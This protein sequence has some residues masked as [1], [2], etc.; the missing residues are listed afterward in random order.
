[1]FS[2]VSRRATALTFSLIASLV[3]QIIPVARRGVVFAGTSKSVKTAKQ[4]VST[5]VEVMPPAPF[6]PNITA[7]KVDA[8]PDPNSDGKAEPGETITYTVTITNSGTDATGVQ[9]N[10]TIDPNTTLVNG[11]TATQPIAVPDS[12]NV[13]GNVRIQPNAAAGFLANDCDPDPAGGP[14][15]NS[16]LTVTTLAGDNSAPFA[17]TSTQSGQVTS[18]T[19]D[20]SFAYNPPPGFAGTDTFTYTVT[21]GTGKTDTATVTLQVGN[22][23][24]SPGANVI[25]FINPAAAAGGDGRLTAPFNCFRGTSVPVTGPTCFSDTAA[26]DPGDT[27]FLFSGAHTSGYT[28]LNNQKLVGAGALATLASIAGVTVQTYS[29]ALPATSQPSPTL[30]S[31][32]ITDSIALG[33]GNTIRGVTFGD[34]GTA[35]GN[36]SDINGN[37]FGTLTILDVTL[38]GSGRALNL[39][40]GTLAA[41]STIDA[42]TVTASTG[43]GVNLDTVAGSLTIAGTTSI[44]NQTAGQTSIRIN[45]SSGNFTFGTT[46]LDRRGSAG[47]NIIAASGTIQFGAVT[48]NNQNSSGTSAVAIDNTTGTGSITLASATVDNNN[49]ASANGIALSGNS[50]TININGGA[51]TNIAATG[52]GIQVSSAGNATVTVAASVTNSAGRSVQVLNRNGG[53]TTLSGNINDTGTGI[54]VA[55]NTAGTITFSGAT[56]TVN[57]GTNQAVTLN[58]NAGATIN[59]SNGGL[60]ITTTSGTGFNASGGG[61]ISVT[62]GANNNTISSGSGGAIIANGVAL[63]A[64]FSSVNSTGGT[65]DVSL[66]TVTGTSNFGSGALSGATGAAFFV[67]G[68]SATVTYSGTIT[69]NTASQKAVDISG[70]TGGT[71]TLSGAIGSNGGSGVSIAGT[72]GT[73]TISGDMTLNNSASVFSA[74]GSGLTVNATGTNNTIGATNAATTTAGYDYQLHHRLLGS[75]VQ[76]H[77]ADRRSKAIAI[78]NAGTLGAFTVTGTGTTAG[79]GGTIQNTTG[80]S[81]EVITFNKASGN[82]VVLNNMTFNNNVTTNTSPTGSGGTC[83]THAGGGDASACGAVLFFSS[84]TGISLTNTTIDGTT[85]SSLANGIVGNNVINMTLTQVTVKKAGNELGEDGLKL[86]GIAGTVNLDRVTITNNISNGVYAEP[87]TSTMNM[88]VSGGTF[89]NNTAPNGQQGILVVYRGTG[90]T[91]TVQK[92]GS[93]VGTAFQNIANHAISV[94][95]VASAT[96]ATVNFNIDSA[97]FTSCNAAID[98]PNGSSAPYNFNVTN[99][100]PH[101]HLRPGLYDECL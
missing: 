36:A 49:A 61:T 29:D 10:D 39:V 8:F 25:W 24:A 32:S 30:T 70:I 20:G 74:S 50:G 100:N 31:G 60:G 72:G 57:T 55:N 52:T 27:I 9:F 51:V 56:K 47:I 65:H 62:T 4:A 99:N 35:T 40:N 92:D 79:S 42:L 84:V 58:T 2:P 13:I 34:S 81:V 28:L 6:A 53:T 90:G 93:N 14:C 41:G 33:T 85:N 37:G 101:E 76:E 22:G 69:Q 21:D 82:S 91:V 46:N 19:T 38:N 15:T 86:V 54:N 75:Y 59:F 16:G 23:T 83:G 66:T 80:R 96:P 98:M 48:I 5:N 78:N 26:D 11:S 45:A 3:F 7:T 44:D 68:G 94:Q 88:T 67:S 89:G 18:S 77:L 73:V 12:Y 63:N 95:S 71:I 64:S 97:T 17:G 43:G 87:F 1:M